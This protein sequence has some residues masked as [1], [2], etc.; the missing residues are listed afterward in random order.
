MSQERYRYINLLVEFKGYWEDKSGEGLEA[1][2]KVGSSLRRECS[3][4]TTT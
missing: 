3:V 2:T 4:A 1:Q